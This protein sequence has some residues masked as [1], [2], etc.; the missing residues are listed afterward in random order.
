MPP[1]GK[2]T[3]ARRRRYK[4]LP[5]PVTGTAPGS[6]ESQD[7]AEGFSR[8]IQAALEKAEDAGW[9]RGQDFTAEVQLRAVVS[10]YN[11]GAIDQYR[12]TIVPTGPAGG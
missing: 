2:K 11:P 6:P 10:R 1:A 5:T 7:H 3:P 9:P 12:A 8:A 4:A